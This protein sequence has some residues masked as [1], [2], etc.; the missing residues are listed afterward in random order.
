[1]AEEVPRDLGMEGWRAVQGKESRYEEVK[2]GLWALSG[3]SKGDI[4]KNQLTQLLEEGHSQVG[5]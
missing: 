5:F 1:M 2:W 3:Q 4:E